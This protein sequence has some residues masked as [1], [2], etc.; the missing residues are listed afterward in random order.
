M[1]G[2]KIAS[3][4]SFD[5]MERMSRVEEALHKSAPHLGEIFNPPQNPLPTRWT[6]PPS[7]KLKPA[8]APVLDSKKKG[9]ADPSCH[10]ER[11]AGRV[12]QQVLSENEMLR[13]QM[14]EKDVEVAI[15]LSKLLRSQVQ[16]DWL[17]RQ[18]KFL[19]KLV[20][21]N[22]KLVHEKIVCKKNSGLPRSSKSSKAWRV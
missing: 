4:L 21:K 9:F 12:M 1:Y 16:R 14:L 6:T 7:G 15:A 19:W 11:A 3:R 17:L 13:Q 5:D 20:C 22:W 18:N 10:G 2:A 8:S